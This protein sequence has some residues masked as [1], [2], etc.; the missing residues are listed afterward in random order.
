MNCSANTRFEQNFRRIAEDIRQ[1]TLKC[2]H[3][4]RIL[5]E[6]AARKPRGNRALR[7]GL[8]LQFR[9]V[10]LEAGKDLR[11]GFVVAAD[12][13]KFEIGITNFKCK[14]VIKIQNM[15]IVAKYC[16]LF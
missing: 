15:A 13:C 11:R 16:Y 10:L 14:Q 2:W 8:A 4:S 6:Y 1:F 3:L 9:L 12:F 7:C 5:P